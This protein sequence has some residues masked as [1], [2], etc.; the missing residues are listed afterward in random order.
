MQ[1]LSCRI[2]RRE[3]LGFDNH[4]LHL[5]GDFE[6][7]LPGQF[8]MLSLCEGWPVLLPRPFSYFD[9]EPGQSATIL[10]K[11]I[12]PGSRALVEAEVGA[13]LLLTGPLGGSFPD[14]QAS[15]AS[16]P[17]CIAGGVGLAPFLLWARQRLA[18]AG[19]S[20]PLLYG[21]A[22]RDML[23]GR[24]PF[25]DGAQRWHLS[26]DDGS[27]GFHGNV[28]DLYKD[29]LARGEVSADAPVYCCGPDPMM[30]AVASFCAA[31]G[32]DCFVSLETYMA[33]GYGVCNGCSVEVKPVGRFE[34]KKYVKTCTEGPVFHAEEL[35]W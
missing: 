8:C 17:V 6:A 13:R 7:A 10:I 35:R 18:K 15:G 19:R 26:T 23:V 21:A 33:C 25:A 24:E 16:E 31:E 1:A 27:E 4:V 20:V 5:E 14:V 22:S 12:G 9:L 32:R 29:L 34:G 2:R 28:L 11:T 30:K 3:D